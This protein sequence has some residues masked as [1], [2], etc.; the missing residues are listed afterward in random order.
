[1]DLKELLVNGDV[2][3]TINTVHYLSPFNIVRLSDYQ[4]LIGV[5][6]F[7]PVNFRLDLFYYNL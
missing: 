2:T 5:K 1:M 7:K 6:C 4:L 3:V